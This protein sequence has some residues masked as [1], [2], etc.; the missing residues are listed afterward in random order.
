MTFSQAR[1]D[2]YAKLERAIKE[3]HDLVE[4]ECRCESHQIET[5]DSAIDSWLVIVSELK[6]YDSDNPDKPLDDEEMENVIG[7]YSKRGSLPMMNTA[8][9]QEYLNRCLCLSVR[10]AIAE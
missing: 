4:I 2:A 5:S 3:L 6:M 1:I 7:T 10:N 9:A 8:L